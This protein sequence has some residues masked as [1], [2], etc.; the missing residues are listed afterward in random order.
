MD[1]FSSSEW[2]DKQNP[3]RLGKLLAK[4]SWVWFKDGGSWGVCAGEVLDP[5]GATLKVRWADGLVLTIDRNLC[6]QASA[7]GSIIMVDGERKQISYTPTGVILRRDPKDEEEAVTP[8]R[9]MT[10]KKSKSKK[11]AS[12]KS[13]TNKHATKKKNT[14]RKSTPKKSQT[15][16]KKKKTSVRA[17]LV[18]WQYFHPETDEA[19]STSMKI[20]GPAYDTITGTVIQV[21]KYN[22][23]TTEFHLADGNKRNN[24]HVRAATQEELKSN[25]AESHAEST[26]RKA[27]ST[28]WAPCNNVPALGARL[29]AKLAEYMQECLPKTENTPLH[30]MFVERVAKVYKHEHDKSAPAPPDSDEDDSDAHMHVKRSALCYEACQKVLEQVPIRQ[31]PYKSSA[32]RATKAILPILEILFDM[33]GSG[34]PVGSEAWLVKMKTDTKLITFRQMAVYP[35]LMRAH[36]QFE[37]KNAFNVKGEL[38]LKKGEIVPTKGYKFDPTTHLPKKLMIKSTRR[39]MH[40]HKDLKPLRAGAVV[41]AFGELHTDGVYM[42]GLYPRKMHPD[43]LPKESNR[44][45]WDN[46]LKLKLSF[47]AYY[48]DAQGNNRLIT[49]PNHACT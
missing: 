23:S 6:R 16:A 30:Y 35:E 47:H 7:D 8:R 13:A 48:C 34:P 46:Y 36:V 17:K 11:S 45:K 37:L 40:K 18:R 20:P 14:K 32:R 4:G 49:H 27:E 25:K 3:K 1:D 2:C 42:Q 39:S 29:Q 41:H 33:P 21:V 28:S 26:S 31:R 5:F 43:T 9:A 19:I 22:S 24:R 10:G 44:K 15:S 38:R 12:K